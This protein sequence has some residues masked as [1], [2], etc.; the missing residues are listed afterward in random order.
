[1]LE[2]SIVPDLG[3]IEPPHRS[4]PE[5]IGG[6]AIVGRLGVGAMGEVFLGRSAAGRLVAVKTIK[7]ELVGEQDFRAR[8][9]TE[10]A[11]ARRVSGAFT[12]A[13]IAADPD[14]ARPWLATVYVPA[15][16]LSAVVHE[17]GPLPVP[18][19]RW[20]GAGCAEALESI[21]AAGLVHR[22]LKPSNVLV[23]LDGPRVIDFGLAK[24]TDRIA[25]T[26][27]N[28]AVGTPAYMAPEQA[29]DSRQAGVASDI[30]A[31]GATMLFAATGHG[32]YQGE[33]VMDV[34]SRLATEPPDVSDLPGELVSVVTACLSRDPR[35]RPTSA[36]ILAQLARELGARTDAGEL[37]P[38]VLPRPVVNLI[39]DH[40]Q[41]PRAADQPTISAGGVD[42][43]FDSQPAAGPLADPSPPAPGAAAGAARGAGAQGAPLRPASRRAGFG[44]LSGMFSPGVSGSG[45]ATRPRLPT[46][47]G[48]AVALVAL[49]AGGAVIGSYLSGGSA[50]SGSGLGNRAHGL[51]GRGSRPSDSPRRHRS[52]PPGYGWL[53]G[54]PPPGGNGPPPGGQGP[55]QPPP[56]VPRPLLSVTRRF[57]GHYTVFTVHGRQW[58]PG[59]TVTV[60][61]LDVGT[62]PTHPPID[63]AGNFTFVLNGPHSFFHKRLS[64]VGTYELQVSAPGGAMAF[65]TLRVYHT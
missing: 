21:H 15:P 53:P 19:V 52:L 45:T 63:A 11:A 46:L 1:M 31:L 5:R 33:T 50:G 55:P 56:G 39:A 24:A 20:L 3:L 36:A 62:A 44:W 51:P 61:L 35:E 6:Y 43:T 29:R 42:Q 23:S 34:L 57:N 28:S 40:R 4:D 8:F 7:L 58:P 47:I 25:L 26:V 65:H 32:P 16:A 27:A 2:G 14:A 30:Y 48:V 13:V 64:L 17:C 59:L 60:T 37:G 38:H 12:A 54:G 22:D 41:G 9:A 18:A 49:T 10:V